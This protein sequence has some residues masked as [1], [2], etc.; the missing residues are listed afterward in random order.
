VENF[1]FPFDEGIEL[2]L[3][4]ALMPEYVFYVLGCAPILFVCIDSDDQ[5]YLCSCC[6]FGKEW[7]VSRVPNNVLRALMKDRLTIR[8][9]FE[10]NN[11]PT[12]FACWN[13]KQ[14]SV[15][16]QVPDNALPQKGSFLE[17]GAK[18]AKY[19]EKLGKENKI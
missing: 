9:A 16:R 10:A 14:F 2:P 6:Q 8:D 18:T 5:R 4:G 3:L 17:L 11:S 1:D 15:S 12:Y 7:V 19:Y 13:G